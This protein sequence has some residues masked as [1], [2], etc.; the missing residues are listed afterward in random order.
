[1]KK[2]FNVLITIILLLVISNI[3]YAVDYQIS[4]DIEKQGCNISYN[5]K[6]VLVTSINGR[7]YISKDGEEWET[8][9][10]PYFSN[11][12]LVWDGEKYAVFTCRGNV[13]FSNDGIEWELKESSNLS[14]FA[15]EEIDED[16]KKVLLIKEVIWTG[17]RFIGCNSNSARFFSSN[18]GIV[19]EDNGNA[20]G[21][22]DNYSWRQFHT[23]ASN[24]EITVAG[25]NSG[26]TAVSYDGVTWK[27]TSYTMEDIT[28]KYNDEACFEKIIWT[29]D[30]FIAIGNLGRGAC[31]EERN[32][33]FSSE[34]G[35]TW[36]EIRAQKGRSEF[37]NIMWNGSQVIVLGKKY[38]PPNEKGQSS[39]DHSYILSSSDLINWE[40]TIISEK[41]IRKMTLVDNKIIAIGYALVSIKNIP[42]N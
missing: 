27:D 35:C 32:I 6:I 14:D 17:K 41:Y 11:H 16:T 8:H 5:G 12:S 1:M 33:I 29:G 21:A 19:W 39:V 36:K 34:D 7:A 24:G 20:E 23:I 31:G 10:T 40:K 30:K 26:R 13:Y 28:L 4:E 18:D 42:D 15:Y 22:E 2:A 9:G 25:G 37:E 38:T 3:S